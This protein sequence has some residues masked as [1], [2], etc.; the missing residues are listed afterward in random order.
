MLIY[1]KCLR[2]QVVVLCYTNYPSVSIP[3][4]LCYV[5]HSRAHNMQSS[6]SHCPA[7]RLIIIQTNQKEFTLFRSEGI[8]NALY[9]FPLALKCQ[10]Y[11][12]FYGSAFLASFLFSSGVSYFIHF[13]TFPGHFWQ[14]PVRGMNFITTLSKVVP[15]FNSFQNF[16]NDTVFA[17]KCAGFI[18]K[19]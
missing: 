8:F 3:L 2:H 9:W 18:I 15:M 11:L 17:A 6:S 4:R 19:G 16:I 5:Y 10:T 1:R 12:T 14:R 7:A 13:V